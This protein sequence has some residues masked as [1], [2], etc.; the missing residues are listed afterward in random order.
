LINVI[1]REFAGVGVDLEA[2]DPMTGVAIDLV[3][4]DHLGV[5]RG[6]VQ[7]QRTGHKGEPEKLF[8]LARRAMITHSTNATR[9]GNS[10][11]IK[12]G[13]TP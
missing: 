11:S 12:I 7:R 4:A 3:E 2:F 8:Q 9:Y 5:G 13:T 6:R 1:G 10:N